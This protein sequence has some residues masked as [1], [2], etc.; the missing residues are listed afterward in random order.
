MALVRTPQDDVGTMNGSWWLC[1]ACHSVNPYAQERCYGC[2]RDR[3]VPVAPEAA[4][5][6]QA[7]ATAAQAAATGEPGDRSSSLAAVAAPGPSEAIPAANSAS[8]APASPSASS[9]APPG[10]PPLPGNARRLALAAIALV[11]AAALL[12]LV[13]ATAAGAFTDQ[14][15]RLADATTQ[16]CAALR[17]AADA[18]AEAAGSTC[19]N[20]AQEALSK[21][22]EAGRAADRWV[23]ELDGSR[24]PE[25]LSARL[26]IFRAHLT[27]IAFYPGRYLDTCYSLAAALDAD[28]TR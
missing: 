5:A 12:A 20:V 23:R 4:E 15:R 22:W 17:A 27:E 28:A 11:L 8:P 2:D 18:Q 10:A 6:A 7:A 1:P 9:P 26:A 14:G 21:T 19:P 16:M 24:P 3:G 13:A 25:E